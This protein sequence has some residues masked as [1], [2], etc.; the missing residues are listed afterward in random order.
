[1]ALA[2]AVPADT[3]TSL[4]AKAEAARDS[5]RLDEASSF[6]RRALALRSSW[7]DGWWSLGT[8]YYD[9]DQYGEAVSAFRHLLEIDPKNGTGYAM[10]GLCEF[11]LGQD[12]LALHDI[13]IGLR[14]GLLTDDAL[15]KVVLY[16]EG[17]LL[18]RQ[19][20]FGSAQDALSL[21]AS[22][23][24]R[25]DQLALALGM[26]VLSITPQNLP[27]GSKERGI[28]LWAGRAETLGAQKDVDQ[29]E[30]IYAGLVAEAPVF[31]NLHYA[32][33]RYLLLAHQPDKA[34]AEFQQ[35]IKNNPRH[36]HSY[37]Y[38]AAIRYRLDSADGVKYAADAV[39]LDPALPFGHYVLGLLYAD[40]HEYTKAIP[41]LELAAK[42]MNRRPDIYYALGN[43]Y[44]RVGRDQDAIRAREMFRRLSAETDGKDGPNIYGDNPPVRIDAA[45]AQDKQRVANREDGNQRP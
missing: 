2:E 41:E 38:I 6:Y 14:L 9:R 44:A 34:V 35:E 30:K 27:T 15:R 1:M 3:F 11:E 22:Y 8:I 24:V 25:E 13:Q 32:Y 36:T 17:T 12:A 31:P 28:V 18:L 23:G 20:R 43:A 29:G 40:T 5:N 33:G 7:K 10:L 26:A 19:A 16:H 39:R 21:L 4:A 37:L 45:G 42:Q